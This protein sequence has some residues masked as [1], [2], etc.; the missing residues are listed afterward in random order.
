MEREHIAVQNVKDLQTSGK[1]WLEDVLGQRLRD[2]QQVFIMVFTPGVVPSDAARREAIPGLQQTWDQVERHQ[3][4]HGITG[5]EF[6]AAVD[7][8]VQDIRRREP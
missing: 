4:E 6:D 8:A 7:E 3:R 1:H 5:E 2:N